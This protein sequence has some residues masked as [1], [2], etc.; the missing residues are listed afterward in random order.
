MPGMVLS[1]GATIVNATS[2]SQGACRLDWEGDKTNEWPLYM[3]DSD[4]CYKE[5]ENGL[6]AQILWVLQ[7]TLRTPDPI[8]VSWGA[9]GACECPLPHPLLVFKTWK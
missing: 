6:Q 4:K 2:C 3:S 1:A 5:E 7:V 9:T 8:W